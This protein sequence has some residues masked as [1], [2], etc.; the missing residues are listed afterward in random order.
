MEKEI[1]IAILGL[2]KSGKT[3]FINSLGRDP[4]KLLSLHTAN[5]GRTKITVNYRFVPY[6][7]AA[8]ARLAY[9]NLDR[10]KLVRCENQEDKIY[11]F[12]EIKKEEGDN[13]RT[14]L[15]ER[16]CEHVQNL[17]IEDA[18]KIINKEGAENY[19]TGITIKIPAF[20]E[21]SQMLKEKDMVLTIRDTRGMLDMAVDRAMDGKMSVTVPSLA[22]LGLDGIN[23]VLFMGAETM[24]DSVA[25]L[26]RDILE[27]VMKAVPVFVLYRDDHIGDKRVTGMEEAKKSV[28]EIRKKPDYMYTKLYET[29]VFL[30]N[31]KIV[32]RD[33][34]KRKFRYLS[35]DFF[36][37]EDTEYAVPK[38][39]YLSRRKAGLEV[40]ENPMEDSDYVSYSAFARFAIFDIV[41]KLLFYY[42]NI[43]GILQGEGLM[44]ELRS[45][46]EE[47]GRI[48]L[49]DF[50][51]YTC[52][53]ASPTKYVYPRVEYKNFIRI[54]QELTDRNV[55]ILGERGGI[56]TPCSNNNEMKYAATA[57]SA[58]TLRIALSSRLLRADFYG[59]LP[60]KLRFTEKEKVQITRKA[61]RYILY[62]QFTDTDAVIQN[63][64]FVDRE[65]MYAN[66]QKLR[67]N[68]ISQEDAVYELAQNVYE[69]FC[70]KLSALQSAD[71]WELI[72]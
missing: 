25:E 43:L 9:L 31:L 50:R 59:K 37:V 28:E 67:E 18:A 56:T 66:I 2:S 30:E 23:A 5:N 52:G 33:T 20:E 55:E 57:I 17:S 44:E 70:V 72:K 7:K 24:Q 29:M 19:I 34:E 38:S 64:L 58:V 12:F 69:A 40:P 11:D 39:E 65:I 48:I 8:E 15:Y 42:E 46:R 51:K 63:Y 27:T 14:A 36:S 71:I 68:H 22:K 21:L 54:S 45:R 60:S 53:K 61:L 4:E 6:E 49:D 62:K 32:E 41:E 47:F 26:Y 1:I 16:I 35:F 13:I 3:S 10:E